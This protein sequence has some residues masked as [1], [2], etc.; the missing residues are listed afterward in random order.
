MHMADLEAFPT[1][2]RRQGPVPGL[3]LLASF[4]G[5]AACFWGPALTSNATLLAQFVVAAI[6]TVAAI[7]GGLEIAVTCLVISTAPLLAPVNAR[8]AELESIAAI[9]VCA[10]GGI[11]AV[12]ARFGA[13]RALT[14]ATGFGAACLGCLCFA[15]H[16]YELTGA[17]SEPEMLPGAALVLTALGIAQTLVATNI[18]DR[19]SVALTALGGFLLCVLVAAIASLSAARSIRG[20]VEAHA[21]HYI[22]ERV[23]AAAEWVATLRAAIEDTSE[24][25][26]RPDLA[27]MCY[28][29][30]GSGRCMVANGVPIPADL[31]VKLPR[32]DRITIEGPFVVN[33][34]YHALI[35]SPRENGKRL[36]ALISMSGLLAALLP[37]EKGTATSTYLVA[38]GS[39]YVADAELGDIVP[40]VGARDMLSGRGQGDWTP[41]T[42]AIPGTTW[43][44]VELADTSSWRSAAHVNS[45]EQVVLGV[46]AGLVVAVLIMNLRLEASGEGV[47]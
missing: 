13:G 20:E 42:A 3:A 43:S 30:L 12:T 21:A 37:S 26:A 45:R 44:I 8:S 46:L 2:G 7:F 38:G 39:T 28:A 24:I 5:L 34:G 31:L 19:I 25:S 32:E 4:L 18:P 23:E 1:A 29:D 11:A 16:H 40:A 22:L 33:E 41:A 36:V 15:T 10:G 17:F 47:E 14:F 27:G 35:S 9:A 6:A